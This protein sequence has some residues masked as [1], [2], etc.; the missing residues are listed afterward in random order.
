MQIIST[1]IIIALY[2]VTLPFKILGNIIGWLTGAPR[3]EA[4]RKPTRQMTD[5]EGRVWAGDDAQEVEA[6]SYR[7]RDFYSSNE[8]TQAAIRVHLKPEYIDKQDSIK[9]LKEV[10]TKLIAEKE[11]N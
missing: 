4:T 9:H 1:L 7:L 10:L 11:A 6:L 8:E 5:E 3:T 2:L